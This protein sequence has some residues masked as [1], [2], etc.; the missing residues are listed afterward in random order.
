[1]KKRLL[2]VLLL[3]SIPAL[4]CAGTAYLAWDLCPAPE[5]EYGFSE[6]YFSCRTNSGAD[7][8]FVA[9]E[10]DNDLAEFARMDATLE[11]YGASVPLP[12]W[13]HVVYGTCRQN[14]MTV[15]LDFGVDPVGECTSPW[16]GQTFCGINSYEVLN[17]PTYP[18][19]SGYR[20]ARLRLS[21]LRTAPGPLQAGV[22]YHAFMLVIS[23]Q[24]TVG[25]D[26]CA[27]CCSQVGWLSYV[28][29]SSAEGSQHE[30][31][32]GVGYALWQGLFP[33]PDCGAVPARTPTWGAIKSL[34][35]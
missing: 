10:L 3:L 28:L 7:T 20:L 1:M 32:G 13:W 34:Y 30:G 35:R 22:K 12:D 21:A 29:V 14:A 17:E 24:K 26:V 23:H 25:A 19:G 18:P 8:L 33:N 4:A 16:E 5:G 6:R 31:C 15:S 9:F 11:L 2:L 27:G